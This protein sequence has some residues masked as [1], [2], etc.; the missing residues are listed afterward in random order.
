MLEVKHG[1]DPGFFRRRRNAATNVVRKGR[2]CAVLRGYGHGTGPG[3]RL[4]L[5]PGEV[6][7]RRPPF[8]IVVDVGNV[9]TIALY[10]EFTR[11]GGT[12]IF[13]KLISLL[14]KRHV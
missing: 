9:N 7:E 5:P 2:Q 10:S 8:L 3:L 12:C 11:T 14:S 1:N 13:L 4:N 6:R